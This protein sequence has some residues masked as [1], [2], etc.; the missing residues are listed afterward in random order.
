[1]NIPDE[2]HDRVHRHL[3]VAGRGIK[4]KRPLGAGTDGYVWQTT[5]DTAV[6]VFKYKF[7][8]LIE[9][10]T[11]QRLADFGVTK[12]IDGFAVPRMLRHDDDLMTVEMDLMIKPPY[13]IDFAK[14]RLNNSPDFSEEVLRYHEEQGRERFEHNWPAV[15]SLMAALESLLIYYLDPQRGNIAFPDMP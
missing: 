4:I 14:V 6:K 5:E 9:R 11:Y 8:Y 7:G 10:D 2:I 3:I 13:I 15:Q 1:M 12:E